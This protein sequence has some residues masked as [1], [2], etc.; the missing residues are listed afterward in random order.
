MHKI[1]I[2][3][4]EFWNTR[5]AINHDLPWDELDG[6]RFGLKAIQEL[7]A[8]PECDR[9]SKATSVQVDQKMFIA[10][11]SK[12]PSNQM[13]EFMRWAT[14]AIMRYLTDS[15][16]FGH[17]TVGSALSKLEKTSASVSS[18]LLKAKTNGTT[19]VVSGLRRG[20]GYRDV[21]KPFRSRVHRRLMRK[22]RDMRRSSKSATVVTI[23]K[24][25]TSVSLAG[26]G[27]LPALELGIQML[28]SSTTMRVSSQALR[29]QMAMKTTRA[30]TPR[31]PPK[32]K[33]RSPPS[34]PVMF[35]VALEQLL[36]LALQCQHNLPP[37]ISAALRASSTRT[38]TFPSRL[39]P[40]RTL[41]LLLTSTKPLRMFAI[42]QKNTN[43]LLLES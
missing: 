3:L 40:I 39:F 2:A 9:F 21:H 1:F 42:C 33:T 38:L 8:Y 34:K 25:A 36:T 16:R 19:R 43:R 24:I 4:R 11:N 27:V 14:D 29:A 18:L 30:R 35:A 17:Y 37:R 10:L 23:R 5:N 7:L 28:E 22:A 20:V 31:T 6:C 15:S 12:D 26:L 32:G 41:I 13:A